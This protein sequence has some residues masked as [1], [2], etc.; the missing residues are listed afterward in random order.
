MDTHSDYN[1]DNIKPNNFH[2]SLNEDEQTLEHMLDG[3]SILEL[4]YNNSGEVI[5]YRFLKVNNAFKKFCRIK[6]K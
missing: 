1:S 6:P 2:F 4:I 3:F 5:D